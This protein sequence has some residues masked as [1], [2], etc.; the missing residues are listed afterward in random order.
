MPAGPL[1]RLLLWQVEEDLSHT[2]DLLRFNFS[3]RVYRYWSRNFLW[4]DWN[5]FIT[6]LIWSS[7]RFNVA[8]SAVFT[9]YI[10]G[11]LLLTGCV[12]P[13]IRR[14]LYDRGRAKGKGK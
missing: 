4:K 9:I 11:P 1:Q 6:S 13:V 8:M 12:M 2:I 14:H 3:R 10:S 7:C 5:L